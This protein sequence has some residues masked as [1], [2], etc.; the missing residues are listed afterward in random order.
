MRF[1]PLAKTL[2][3]AALLVSSS[4]AVRAQNIPI[5]PNIPSQP[6]NPNIKLPS[7]DVAS[8]RASNTSSRMMRLRNAPDGFS[9]ENINLKSL[10]AN[11]YG[12]RQDL[13]TGGPS[14]IN[15]TGFDVEAKVAG[16]DIATFNKL[17]DRQRASLLQALLTDRFHLKLHH[18]IRNLPM[19]DLVIAKG[20]SKLKPAAPFT[21]PPDLP[22]NPG[23]MRRPGML[24]MG[25]GMI[26]GDAL[27]IAAI[28]NQLSYAVSSTVVDKTGLAGNYD[29]DLKWQPVNS[30][31]AANADDSGVSI[32]TAVQEQL[33]LKLQPT[34]GPVDTLV[35]DQ[36]EKPSEN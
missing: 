26:Q 8:I 4:L 11:A 2:L 18:E 20:G 19:Y 31:P 15:S 27:P 7:Y 22:M 34:K 25:P 16:P 5:A 12:I 10:I 3:L 21:P 29:F 17:S 1:L 23:A 36:A 6:E 13:I 30:G 28:A 14:W 35:I 33:G 24:R 9:C 32:F